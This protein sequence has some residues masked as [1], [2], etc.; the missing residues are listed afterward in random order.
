MTTSPDLPPLP[1]PTP[2]GR[3]SRLGALLRP[4][5][6]SVP[7]ALS[8]SAGLLAATA[9]TQAEAAD[10]V[11]YRAQDR[12]DP[13][14]VAR[15][16]SARPDG[17]PPGTRTRSIR[18]LEDG[19]TPGAPAGASLTPVA[20]ANVYAA[21]RAPTTLSLPVPFAFDSA[22]ILPDARVQLDAVAE[23]ILLLP[24]DRGVVIEGHTDAIGPDG[25]NQALSERRARAVRTYL[26]VRHGIAAQ[27]LS[28]IGFGKAMPLEGMRPQAGIN[29]RVQFR[30]S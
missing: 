27:R 6:L 13:S 16:L 7:L 5:A 8:L 17:L 25:Y 18:L 15:I 12:V 21:G 1:A 29:R 2:S 10:V 22:E 23:G 19:A 4:L 26:V 24:G 30:G 11:V 3:R 20:P 9:P 28:T 14:A